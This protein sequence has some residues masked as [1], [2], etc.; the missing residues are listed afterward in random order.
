MNTSQKHLIQGTD[1]ALADNL[2][3]QFL[4]RHDKD[5]DAFHQL[6]AG[7]KDSTNVKTKLALGKTL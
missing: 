4:R 1:P 5:T 7:I 2:S 3:L 6:S